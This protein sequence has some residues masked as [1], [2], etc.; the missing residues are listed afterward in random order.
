[1]KE[2]KLI[3]IKKEVVTQKIRRKLA[4]SEK[5]TTEAALHRCF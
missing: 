4:V 2:L 5:F 3:V 1:M